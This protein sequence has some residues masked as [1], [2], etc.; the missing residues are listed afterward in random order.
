MVDPGRFE[1]DGTRPIGP[2]KVSGDRG[3]EPVRLICTAVKNRGAGTD[4]G[5]PRLH[6]S[7]LLDDIDLEAISIAWARPGHV[8]GVEISRILC[9]RDADRRQRHIRVSRRAGK[10]EVSAIPAPRVGIRAR[11]A[12]WINRGL[13]AMEVID[14]EVEVR[15]RGGAGAARDSNDLSTANVLA[16][17]DIDLRE[18]AVKRLQAVAVI[19]LDRQPAQ[20][21]MTVWVEPARRLDG[22]GRRRGHRLVGKRVVVAV[23]P[24]VVEVVV[25]TWCLRIAFGE[26]GIGPARLGRGRGAVI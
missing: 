24:V 13:A 25:P 16:L 8:D 9:R 17:D 19:D 22:A 6:A 11:P 4:A 2:S 20:A 18:V 26:S 10:P 5:E 7:V 21:L 23:V 14:P 3:P 15:A 12:I 1:R